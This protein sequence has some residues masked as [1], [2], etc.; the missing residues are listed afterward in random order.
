MSSRR[1]QTFSEVGISNAGWATTLRAFRWGLWWAL[2][3]AHL[4][5]EP[6]SVDEFAKE[7]GV[8]VRTAYRE[9]AAF[10]R[11]FPHEETP[12]RMNRES[13]L[14]RKADRAWTRLHDLGEASRALEPALFDVG[15][16]P[17]GGT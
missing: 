9:Q 15:A 3:T 8:N 17:V 5:R 10:R 4:K 13:G 14:Q 6:V 7:M 2:A 12:G 16:H 1:R 11:A